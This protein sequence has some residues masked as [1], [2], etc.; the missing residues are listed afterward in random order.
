LKKNA[1][2]AK[3]AILVIYF[4]PRGFQ[5]TEKAIFV[6]KDLKLDKTNTKKAL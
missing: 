5:S 4:A 1:I 2:F 6:P 3:S